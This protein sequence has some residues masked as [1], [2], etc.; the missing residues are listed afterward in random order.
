MNYKAVFNTIGRIVTV[1]ALLLLLPIVTALAYQEYHSIKYFVVVMVLAAVIG[2]V[3]MLVFRNKDRLVFAGEGFVTVAFAWTLMSLIGALPFYLSGAIPS[4]IDAVFEIVSGF[5][6]TGASILTNVEALDKSMLMWRSF[7]H[8]VGGMGVLVFVMAVLPGSSQGSM[9]MI[10][11]EMPGPIIGKLVP[12]V[13]DTAKILYIIYICLTFMEIVFLLLGGMPFFES[14]IHALGTAGTGGFGAKNDSLAGYSPYLQWVVTIFMLIFA[15]NFNIY[16]LILLRKIR[17]AFCSS[18]FWCYLGMVIVSTT[19]VTANIYPLYNTASDAFRHSA[20]QVASIISTTGYSTVDF[21]L[22][23]GLSKAILFILMMTGACAGSTAGGLKISRI[24]LLFKSMCR[25]F[26]RL[27][28]PRSVSKIQYE[29]RKIEESTLNNVH[30]YFVVYIACFVL[31]FLFLCIEPF[32]FETNLSAV[33]A[34]FNNVGPGFGAVGPASNYA[35]YSDF[36]KILLSFAMLLG[37]LEIFPL[38]IAFSPAT[39]TKKYR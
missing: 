37:R 22:W 39:W 18:E 12:K 38:I 23:P 28:H 13:K 29:G 7:S 2:A 8:W 15:V 35:M 36:S 30:V 3:L 33:A 27:L 16:Y 21:N 32:D 6:T 9:H 14:V 10:R 31:I 26:R 24:V 4:Y 11:A 1:E 17:T 5:T 20:F 19:V 25:E 34:C